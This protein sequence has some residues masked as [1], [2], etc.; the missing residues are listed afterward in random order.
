MRLV[1]ARIM[2][3]AIGLCAL[4]LALIFALGQNGGNFS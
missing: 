3:I 4:L 1:F 2:A